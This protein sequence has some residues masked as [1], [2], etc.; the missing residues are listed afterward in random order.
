MQNFFFSSR[1]PTAGFRYGE[2]RSTPVPSVM[3]RS[4]T[5]AP[6]PTRP[7]KTFS[8]SISS[9]PF[10]SNNLFLTNGTA[11]SHSNPRNTLPRVLY[12]INLF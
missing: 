8:Q 2:Q 9:P 7:N 11:G 6:Q 4:R 1:T 5:P 3:P 10:S 12:F